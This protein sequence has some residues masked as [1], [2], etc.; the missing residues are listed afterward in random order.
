MFSH[1]TDHPH[2]KRNRRHLK[3]D[4]KLILE[5]HCRVVAALSIWE[6]QLVKVRSHVA[7]FNLFIC[8]C[9]CVQVY[10]VSIVTFILTH[11]VSVCVTSDTILNVSVDLNI[12]PSRKR[13]QWHFM[14][15][16]P[17]KKDSI[18]EKN[19]YE[20]IIQPKLNFNLSR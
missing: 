8:F 14:G 17:S 19:A 1:F 5:H 20:N 9:H 11:F 6:K 3:M 15:W 13:Y 12:K 18:I 4:C 7:S 10:I 16:L 2:N